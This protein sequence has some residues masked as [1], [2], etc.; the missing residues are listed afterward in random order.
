MD[1]RKNKAK[2]KKRAHHV[3]VVDREKRGNGLWI[4]VVMVMFVC[5]FL[6]IKKMNLD[7]E[8]AEY[9]AVL[10]VRQKELEDLEKESKSIEEYKVYV[11]TKSY[12]EKTAREKLG[13]VYEDEIIFKS[14]D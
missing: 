1:N 3:V 13:L 14:E 2:R 4:I 7:Q 12:I 8:R 11:K 10:R 9:A 6:F 5:C